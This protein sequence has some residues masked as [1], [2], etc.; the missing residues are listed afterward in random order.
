MTL[1]RSLFYASI[2]LVALSAVCL[3]QVSSGTISGSVRDSSGGAVVGA[4]VEITQL[5]TT[6][7]RQ[8]VTNER[9]EF[10]APYLRVG[11]YSVAVSM[12]GFKSEVSS[13]IVLQVDQI[14]NL[15]VVLQPGATSESIEVSGGACQWWSPSRG[16]WL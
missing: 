12:P 2:V 15:T 6:E 13:G 1:N 8:T 14:V 5:A 16:V 11:G 4:K 10:S 7:K 3:A 9:G